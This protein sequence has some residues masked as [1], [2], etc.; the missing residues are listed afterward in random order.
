MWIVNYPMKPKPAYSSTPLRKTPPPDRS[1]LVIDSV[2]RFVYPSQILFV[3]HH[4]EDCRSRESTRDLVENESIG[5]G[6][7]AEK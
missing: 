2:L 4:P 3:S 5:E 6:R 1:A 7:R